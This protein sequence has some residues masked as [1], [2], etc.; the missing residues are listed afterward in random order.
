M[1]EKERTIDEIRAEMA[2]NRIKVGVSAANL[3]ESVD[4]KNLV[5]NGIE[6][7]KEFVKGEYASAKAQF[8]EPDGTVNLQ[9]P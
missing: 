5:H 3:R 9:R 8:V 7:T 2:A 1:P 6:E 4:P